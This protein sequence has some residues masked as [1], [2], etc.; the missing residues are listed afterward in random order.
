MHERVQML[1]VCTCVRREQAEA[2]WPQ[3]RTIASLVSQR[4]GVQVPALGEADDVGAR[5]IEQLLAIQRQLPLQHRIPKGN[6]KGVQQ[7]I[8]RWHICAACSTCIANTLCP[9]ATKRMQGMFD[10]GSP[11]NGPHQLRVE[12]GRGETGSGQRPTAKLKKE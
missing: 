2:S 9:H 4:G 1:V 11:C 3:S 8:Q 6:A 12:A 7:L 5:R 10:T